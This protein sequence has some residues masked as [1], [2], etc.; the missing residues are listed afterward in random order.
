M[1]RMWKNEVVGDRPAGR[2]SQGAGYGREL[3]YSDHALRRCRGRGIPTRLVGLVVRFA[4]R[5]CHVGRGCQS[6]MI[7]R[8]RLIELGQDMISPSDRERLAGV[9]VVVSED[10]AIVT[11]LH[12]KRFGSRRYRH[13]VN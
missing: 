2:E 8:G 1:T 13:G 10:G 3:Q 7:S 12:Q 4:D 11:A 5:E 9:S 6:L